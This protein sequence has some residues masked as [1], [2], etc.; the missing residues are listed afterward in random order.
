[1]GTA[2][3]GYRGNGA[4][5]PT[6]DLMLEAAIAHEQVDVLFQPLIEPHRAASSG[7][8]R[9]RA[10]QSLPMRSCSLR[11]Q[12]QAGSTS[13]CRGLSSARRFAAR[14]S[15]K[16]RSKSLGLS[17]NLLPADISRAGYDSWLLDEIE[18]CRHRSAAR[19]RR[20]HRER[21]ARRPGGRRRAPRVASARPG[22]RI[23]VDDFGTGYASLAYLTSLPLGRDQD[24]SRACR[25]HRRRR[26]RPDRRQGADPPCP[27]ARS[28]GR[29]RGRGD[30]GPACAARRMGLRPLPGLPWRRRA[31]PGGAQPLRRGGERRSS[32]L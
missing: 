25:R 3:V 24:R 26:A 13:A 28:Q 4:R 12:P 15:G 23:A 10:R 21:A 11:A 32:S 6:R 17:I 18:R 16:A 1:M 29:G 8:K 7:P 30:D 20:N 31:H 22:I 14:R 5:R 27:R 9:W 19:H 2:G